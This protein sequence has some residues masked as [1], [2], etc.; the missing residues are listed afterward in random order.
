VRVIVA[1]APAVAAMVTETAVK[2][3]TAKAVAKRC[4]CAMVVEVGGEASWSA[5]FWRRSLAFSGV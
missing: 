4:V 3:A 2:V 5:S 1:V